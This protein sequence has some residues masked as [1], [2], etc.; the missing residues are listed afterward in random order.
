MLFKA[1]FKQP[2]G[3]GGQL[4]N[5]SPFLMIPLVKAVVMITRTVRALN[6]R[7]QKIIISL[8]D[9]KLENTAQ[10]IIPCDP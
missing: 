10:K 6:L 1:A 9:A 3:A 7:R 2:I 5:Q 4:G 8:N